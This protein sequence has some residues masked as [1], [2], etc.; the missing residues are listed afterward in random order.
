VEKKEVD[1][2]LSLAVEVD[3]A[4]VGEVTRVL[5]HCAPLHVDLLANVH[6]SGHNPFL[7]RSDLEVE[8]GVEP[9]ATVIEAAHGDGRVD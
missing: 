2:A 6:S 3:E 5:K 7:P 9:V 8:E 4:G 1:L